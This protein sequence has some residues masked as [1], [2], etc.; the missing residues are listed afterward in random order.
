VRFLE[1][2]LIPFFLFFLYVPENGTEVFVFDNLSL[3]YMSVF[4]VDTE[5]QELA[6]VAKRYNASIVFEYLNSLSSKAY[7]F[8]PEHIKSSLVPQRQVEAHL[9]GHLPSEYFVQVFIVAKRT[10]GVVYTFGRLSPL[11][12]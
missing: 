6:L 4:F 12:V 1:K 3:L 7:H 8:R 2:L 5:V 10:M 9:S 11:P